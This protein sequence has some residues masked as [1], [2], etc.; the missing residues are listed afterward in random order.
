M[1]MVSSQHATMNPFNSAHDEVRCSVVVDMR[2]ERT[3]RHDHS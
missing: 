3:L 1:C 2:S